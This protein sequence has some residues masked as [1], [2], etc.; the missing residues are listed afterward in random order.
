[1]N[2]LSALRDLVSRDDTGRQVTALRSPD[3]DVYWPATQALREKATPELVGRLKPL[4]ADP[5]PDVRSNACDPLGYVPRGDDSAIA[6]LEPLLRD[7]I[8]YVSRAAV[9]SLARLGWQ[10]SNPF[11][12]AVCA[13]AMDGGKLSHADQRAEFEEALR[14][15]G[16]D[17]VGLL[18]HAILTSGDWRINRAATEMLAT[19][20]SD[21]VLPTLLEVVREYPKRYVHDTGDVRRAAASAFGTIKGKERPARQ[22]TSLSVPDHALP[23]Q[24]PLMCLSSTAEMAE[25]DLVRIWHDQLGRWATEWLEVLCVVDDLLVLRDADGNTKVR[26]TTD[27]IPC[28]K[29]PVAA[30]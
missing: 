11:E 14:A 23:P 30:A 7:P 12:R 15:L 3:F 17:A 20:E 28:W 16:A 1:M 24:P 10:P 13:L 26:S 29:W 8:F 27:S 6:V 2:L 4:L 25:G 5:D 18:L 19:I 21:S 9:K 22:M